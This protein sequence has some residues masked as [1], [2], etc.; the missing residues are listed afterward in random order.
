M[1]KAFAF[2]TTTVLYQ[3]TRDQVIFGAYFEQGVLPHNLG[4]SATASCFV[5][6]ILFRLVRNHDQRNGHLMLGVCVANL[7]FT[8]TF[9]KFPKAC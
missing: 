8:Q 9:S 3:P 5:L 7:I 1:R 6:K 4:C 2:L